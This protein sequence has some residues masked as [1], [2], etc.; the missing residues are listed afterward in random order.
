[1]N[2]YYQIVYGG[3]GEEIFPIDKKDDAISEYDSMVKAE[4][5]MSIELLKITSKVIKRNNYQT[6]KST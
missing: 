3:L 1:M 5:D 4:P 2:E 6:A